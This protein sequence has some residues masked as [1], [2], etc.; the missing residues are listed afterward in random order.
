MKEN[1]RSI[2]LPLFYQY[3]LIQAQELFALPGLVT[4]ALVGID[5]QKTQNWRQGERLHDM[6][7]RSVFLDS[8]HVVLEGKQKTVVRGK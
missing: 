8:I 6:I 5:G 2:L 3:F 1:D 4:T 7:L